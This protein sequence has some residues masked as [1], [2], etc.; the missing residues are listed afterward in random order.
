[1]RKNLRH[2]SKFES[3]ESG[4]LR[5]ASCCDSGSAPPAPDYAPIA[6][7]N[8]KAAE[9]AYKAAGDDLAFRRQV[10]DES[11]PRQEQLYNL[12]SQVANQQMG[13][14]GQNEARAGEQWQDYKKSYRPN[15]LMTLADA[16]GGQYLDDAS[17]QELH[18]LITGGGNYDDAGR[19]TALRGIA[20]R[21]ENA[22]A[23]TAAQRAVGQVNQAF[24]QQ[25]RQLGRLGAGDPNRMAVMAARLGQNQTL[26]QV[27]AANQAR[28]GVRSTQLGLRTG[29]ANFGRNMPN[30]AGQAFGL[31][32]NAGSA[33]TANQNTGFMSGLPYAQFAAGGYGTQLGAAALGQSGALGMGGLMS[34]DYGANL[35]YQAQTAGGGLGALLGIA[36]VGLNVYQASRL[37]PRM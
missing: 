26:A 30:T 28:E 35:N 18:S 9:Y 19:L 4:D 22:A 36:N 6:G 10:Y 5:Y 20:T 27:G 34:R 31:A 21:A 2:E 16:Y 17:N 32:T 33:A 13:I 29:V 37:S 25:S 24:G 8:E 3:L 15:E 12:A 11:R 7:A 14:A 23:G 1:M